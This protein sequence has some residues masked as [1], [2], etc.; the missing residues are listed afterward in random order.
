MPLPRRCDVI[1]VPGAQPTR[2]A[3]L[4]RVPGVDAILWC[5]KLKLDAEIITAAGE[6]P[7]VPIRLS[8]MLGSTVVTGSINY[9]L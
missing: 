5:S 7:P 2:E 9:Q 4:E 1:V 8:S 6:C 3:V